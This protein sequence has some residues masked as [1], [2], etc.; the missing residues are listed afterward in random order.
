MALTQEFKNEC[1]RI[2]KAWKEI[3]SSLWGK[4]Y[5]DL[6][7]Y[8]LANKDKVLDD[9]FY[10]SFKTSRTLEEIKWM[11]KRLAEYYFDKDFGI[12]YYIDYVFQ[13]GQNNWAIQLTYNYQLL[14]LKFLK[15]L[16]EGGFET[17]NKELDKEKTDKAQLKTDKEAA[18]KQLKVI[19]DYW[20]EIGFDKQFGEKIDKGSLGKIKENLG[21]SGKKG[22]ASLLPYLHTRP[23]F[24]R[25]YKEI[26]ERGLHADQLNI[27]DDKNDFLNN[28]EKHRF[29]I[30]LW[31]S[32]DDY[33]S[34]LWTQ[35]SEKYAYYTDTDEQLEYDQEEAQIKK[36]LKGQ[37][38]EYWTYYGGAT[39]SEAGRSKQGFAITA[40]EII[41]KK[42]KD[43]PELGIISEKGKTAE[44]R[45]NLLKGSTSDSQKEYDI[46]LEQLKQEVQQV[47]QIQVNPN[48]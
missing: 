32:E 47:S 6:N 44:N 9:P 43:N 5:T 34:V 18:E 29:N 10:A 16:N 37:G 36:F 38:F 48:K 24:S 45:L 25:L 42:I 39:D 15:N 30:L 23:V 41:L 21:Q 46:Y 33:W 40:T 20:K 11:N 12:Q 31:K 4:P 2:L 35:Y 8:L 1:D 13:N 19:T 22:K 14:R 28:L 3:I 27:T 17:V 7:N 26:K